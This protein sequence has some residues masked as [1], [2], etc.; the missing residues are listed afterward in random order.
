MITANEVLGTTHMAR[1]RTGFG[2]S[3]PR[4]SPPIEQHRALALRAH[5]PLP[6]ARITEPER[7]ATDG[8][9][10]HGRAVARAQGLLACRDGVA[11]RLL[12]RGL[13][14]RVLAAHDA[15]LTTSFPNC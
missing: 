5:Q 11:D 7:A 13:E 14:L 3:V 4:S 10:R 1:T 6:P 2:A 8:P 9:R 15:I 12:L